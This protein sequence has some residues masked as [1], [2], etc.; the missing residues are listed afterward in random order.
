MQPLS[1]TLEHVR[2]V[3]HMRALGKYGVA[4]AHVCML[5][6]MY[7][8]R[9]DSMCVCARLY[10]NRTRKTIIKYAAH[11]CLHAIS[12]LPEESF[13]LQGKNFRLHRGEREKGEKSMHVQHVRSRITRRLCAFASEDTMCAVP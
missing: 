1:C 12:R 5:V 4:G 13:M 10:I 6:C 2:M 9:I 3:F 8:A 11:A 7:N